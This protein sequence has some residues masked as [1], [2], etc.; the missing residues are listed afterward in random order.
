[1]T[2][3]RAMPGEAHTHK[4]SNH[5]FFGI[6]HNLSRRLGSCSRCTFAGLRRCFGVPFDMFL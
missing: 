1:M 4:K 6:A 5:E 3:M 2:V